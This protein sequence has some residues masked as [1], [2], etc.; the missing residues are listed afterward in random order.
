MSPLFTGPPTAM[1]GGLVQKKLNGLTGPAFII[2]NFPAIPR[3]CRDVLLAIAK[4]LPNS[5]PSASTIAKDAGVSRRTVFRSIKELERLGFIRIDRRCYNSSIYYL[6]KRGPWI[7]PPSEKMIRG[8]SAKLSV[9]GDIGVTR[10]SDSR[11]TRGSDTA[12]TVTVPSN[13][14]SLTVPST[15]DRFKIEAGGEAEAVRKL[16]AGAF[17]N[18]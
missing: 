4:R 11:V 10:G 8:G 13:N 16:I 12:V 2:A 17:G 15:E 14:Q 7:V 5:Y 1:Q 6:D 9:G 3:S 18:V